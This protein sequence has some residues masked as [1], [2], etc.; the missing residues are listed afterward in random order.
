MHK[1]PVPKEINLDLNQDLSQKFNKRST[2]GRNS[3]Q[4]N[5]NSDEE[6]LYRKNHFNIAE[7]PEMNLES[8]PSVGNSPKIGHNM[9]P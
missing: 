4:T 5:R 7:E 1:D 3:V 9:A 6:S 8:G 2:M